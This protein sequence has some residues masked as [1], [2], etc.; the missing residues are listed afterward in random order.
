MSEQRLDAEDRRR[1]R[2]RD[3]YHRAWDLTIHLVHPTLFY[4]LFQL[5]LRDHLGDHPDLRALGIFHPLCL[6]LDAGIFL[7]AWAVFYTTL[8]RDM[9]FRAPSG[10]ILLLS[11]LVSAA[12]QYIFIPRPAEAAAAP[13]WGLLALQAAAAGALWVETMWRWRRLKRAYGPPPE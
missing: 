11:G 2:I 7:G 5:L 12:A 3:H 8:L 10:T 4:L 9:G 6:L 13:V 1:R